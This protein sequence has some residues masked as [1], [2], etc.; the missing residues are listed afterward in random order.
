MS[1]SVW[2]PR[3]SATT[4]SL[5]TTFRSTKL[6]ASARRSR[7]PGRHCDICRS[8]RKVAERTVPGLYRRIRSFVPQVGARECA[9]YFRHAGY[10][11]TECFEL[12]VRE[13]DWIEVGRMSGNRFSLAAGNG[14]HRRA[15][16]PDRDLCRKGRHPDGLNL[17]VPLLAAQGIEH[18]K[19]PIARPA[20]VGRHE[21]VERVDG[22]D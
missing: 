2:F 12:A 17:F 13:L 1:S 19:Q 5:S 3:S 15:Q 8:T 10:V 9:N 4:S 11:S 16:G 7:K 6:L 18:A 21:P 22:Y 14:L 20:N